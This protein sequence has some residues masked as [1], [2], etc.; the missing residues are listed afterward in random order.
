VNNTHN[1]DGGLLISGIGGSPQ[2]ENDS[3]TC[4]AVSVRPAA[5]CA[6]MK[7]A[8]S[9]IVWA[10]V[11]S[12]GAGAKR[13]GIDSWIPTRGRGRKVV[14]TGRSAA[15]PYRAL[16]TAGDDDWSDEL[17]VYRGRRI[18]NWGSGVVGALGGGGWSGADNE[19]PSR[20]SAVLEGWRIKTS[21]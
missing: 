16:D 6:E 4:R 15:T 11:D 13:S 7:R 21:V 17:A 2:A 20:Q 14:V 9:A 1:L 3:T 5:F 8:W 10:G 12:A 19:P 18:H